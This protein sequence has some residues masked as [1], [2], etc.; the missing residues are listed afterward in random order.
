[1]DPSFNYIHVSSTEIHREVVHENARG[2]I[3]SDSIANVV[4]LDSKKGYVQDAALGDAQVLSIN[5]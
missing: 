3:K 2:K 4:D 5:T 1:L